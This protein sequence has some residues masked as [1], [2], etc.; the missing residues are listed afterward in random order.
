MVYDTVRSWWDGVLTN[1]VLPRKAFA[2]LLPLVSWVIWNERNARVFRA[3]AAPVMV[4]VRTIKDEASIWALAGAKHL[5]N[6][7]PRE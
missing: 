7:M 1:I 2:S 6:L 4:I 5:C 3:K